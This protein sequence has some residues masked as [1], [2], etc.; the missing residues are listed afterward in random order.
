MRRCSVAAD[1][2]AIANR[3]DVHHGF[4][5]VRLRFR[6]SA[7]AARQQQIPMSWQAGRACRGPIRSH[8]AAH[9]NVPT[10]SCL[11]ISDSSPVD[12]CQTPAPRSSSIGDVR[13]TATL[14]SA[15]GASRM[16]AVTWPRGTEPFC[17]RSSLRGIRRRPPPFVSSGPQW[18]RD[19]P[20]LHRR[21]SGHQLPR[22]Y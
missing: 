9:V 13:I 2:N 10:R 15:S 1:T 20:S 3:L 22:E 7:V 4:I 21:T 6:A 17:G 16:I 11:R 8:V 19:R 12:A 5:G 14:R 18:V